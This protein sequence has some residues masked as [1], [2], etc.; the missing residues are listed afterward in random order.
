MYDIIYRVRQKQTFLKV[1]N[2]ESCSMQNTNLT[3]D[4]EMH[5]L[6]YVTAIHVHELQTFKNGSV[7]G[8]PYMLAQFV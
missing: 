6:I 4:K 5:S 7:L 3:S 2:I 1:C 8:P